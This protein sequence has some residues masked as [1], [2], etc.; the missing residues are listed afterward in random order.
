MEVCTM[1][2]YGLTNLITVYLENSIIDLA[3]NVIIRHLQLYIN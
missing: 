2:Y 1:S 3:C